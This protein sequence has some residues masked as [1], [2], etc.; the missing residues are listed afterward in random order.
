[1]FCFDID[2][3]NILH[4]V[5]MKKN[6]F[7]TKEIETLDSENVKTGHLDTFRIFNGI[8]SICTIS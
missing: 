5:V 7:Q 2:P 3:F 8:L 4:K 6:C 1:M